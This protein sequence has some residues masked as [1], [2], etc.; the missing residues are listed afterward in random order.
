L[1]KKI[2]KTLQIS[3]VFIGTI[4]GAGLASG[5]EI[6]QFFTCFGYKSFLGILLCGLLYIVIGSMLVKISIKYNL[7][8]YN[9]LIKLVSPGFLGEI[10]DIITS[11]FLVSGAA[12]ILAASGALL[13]Q[14]FGISNWIGIIA[15]TILTLIIL[16]RDTQGLIEINTMIVPTLI[17][18]IVTIFIL[19]VLFSKDSLSVDI[20]KNIPYSKKYWLISTLLYSG[21]NIISSSGVIVPLSSEINNPK[22]LI[23]GITLGS[24]GLTVLCIIINVMLMLNV[25]YIYKYE[26]P[27]LYIANRFGKII[28]IVLLAI[29]WLEMFSTAVS[30]VYSVGKTISNVFGINYKNAVFIILLIAIPISQIGFGTL[31]SILYPAFGVISLIFIIQCTYFYFKYK[32]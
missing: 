2:I 20:I 3:A 11:F 10:T 21:F 9:Q 14:Y 25:P 6:T 22:I 26:I 8:S 31:I 24:I 7:N 17:I 18:V 29:I 30:D 23:V 27:L 28:Q 32:V 16:L 13:H 19:Y 12:I 4:V 5:R 1:Q 15:M